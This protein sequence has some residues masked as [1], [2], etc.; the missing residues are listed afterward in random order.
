[1]KY[2]TLEK[3]S[4]GGYNG[5]MKKTAPILIELRKGLEAAYGDKLARLVL[6]GSRARGDS[7][8]GS[9]WDVAVFLKSFDGL[10]VELD[11]ITDITTSI[12]ENTGE[13]IAP[14]AFLAEE[15]NSQKIPLMYEIR[16]EGVEI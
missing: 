9:D 10:L 3:L 13:L 7:G 11:R 4:K 5:P 2:E 16:R 8:A 12:L 6:Y 14:Q 15:Y 1:M